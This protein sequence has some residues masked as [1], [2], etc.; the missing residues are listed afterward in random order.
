MI[1]WARKTGTATA[2]VVERI[3]G[4]RTY[5]EQGYRSCLGILRLS[6][7]YAPDRVEAAA[8]RALKFN[9]CSYKSMRAILVSG[10]DRESVPECKG[11]G[12]Q[13]SLPLHE[14]IRGQE[15]YR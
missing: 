13:M 4:S 6:H 3:L 1:Q 12:W 7:H 8:R 5:P 14:N 9:T 2:Q 11:P 10:L 15:Y